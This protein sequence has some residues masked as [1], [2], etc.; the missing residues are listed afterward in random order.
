MKDD[1]K[2]GFEVNRNNQTGDASLYN[3]TENSR[4]KN[5][6]SANERFDN[7]STKKTTLRPMNNPDDKQIGLNDLRNKMI[8]NVD[9]LAFNQ[10]KRHTNLYKYNKTY[11]PGRNF[12]KL[13]MVDDNKKDGKFTFSEGFKQNGEVPTDNNFMINNVRAESYD[14]NKIKRQ[15]KNL[16]SNVQVP[17][18]YNDNKTFIDP[19]K[20]LN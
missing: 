13:N 1:L 16:V 3:P 2:I 7:Y 20:K 8:T 17:N 19:V 18:C 6:K 14:N 15:I 11:N 10:D 5:A 12:N 9:A 4:I